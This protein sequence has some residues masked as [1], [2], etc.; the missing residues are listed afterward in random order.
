MRQLLHMGCCICD[1]VGLCQ[2]GQ[3]GLYPTGP[4]PHHHE[5]RLLQLVMPMGEPAGLASSTATPG[6]VIVAKLRLQLPWRRRSRAA[7][8]TAARRA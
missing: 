2:H 4:P 3:H 1:S 8:A 7:A 6:A 5:P